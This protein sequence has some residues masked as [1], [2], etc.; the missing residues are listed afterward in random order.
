[1]KRREGGQPGNRSALKHGIYARHYPEEVKKAFKKWDLG[2][3]AAEIQLL[4]V[5][6]DKMTQVLLAPGNDDDV[7]IKLS[8]AI[9]YTVDSLVK[10]ATKQM[11]FNSSDD[12][13]LVA[14][15]DVQDE[16]EFFEDGVTPE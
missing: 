11:Q 4:R 5:A 14:W 3:F 13:V 7:T 2:D 9:A 15:A 12:P 10:A 16:E 1:M 8:H 6:N